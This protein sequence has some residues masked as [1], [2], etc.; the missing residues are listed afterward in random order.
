MGIRIVPHAAN[1]SAA[2][3]A[4]NHRMRDGGSPWGFYLDP[5]P[6]WIPKRDEQRV[7]REYHLAVE[8]DGTVRGGFALKPQEWLVR[9]QIRIVTDWQGPFSEGAIDAKFGA[10]GL[11]MVR[12]M[13]KKQPLLYSWGHGGNE[14]PV[15]QMIEKMG[16][17]LHQTPVCL[18]ILKPRR[19]LR[20][21]ALLRTTLRRRLLLDTLA[22]SGAGTLGLKAAHLALRLRHPVLFRAQAVEVPSFGPWADTLWQA[23]KDQ[24]AAIAVRDAATMNALLPPNAWP[25]AI[26][27]K[28]LRGGRVLGWAAIM[29]TQMQG[30]HRFG[31]LR[32]G[33]VVDCLADPKDAGEVV[34]A[35]TQALQ[36][37]G[38]DLVISNQAH[39]AWAAAFGQNGYVVLQN[40]RLFAASPE[41]RKALEPFDET[42]Q[43]LHMTN[44]DGHGPMAL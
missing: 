12:D 5:V 34:H 2:V 42:A 24:Y 35:A 21:N 14:Q 6:D 18:R 28:V 22:F 17:T 3:D 41:L 15:V 37:R 43:G 44:L 23:C 31:T 10:L 26:R 16:W 8:D 13:L 4:F 20:L 33:S 32:V 11:R 27:L 19:F 25:S 30:D 7:W 36:A 40:R 38:A 1:Y 39:P 29:D 9:G